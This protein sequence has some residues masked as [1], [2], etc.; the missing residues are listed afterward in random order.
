MFGRRCTGVLFAVLVALAPRVASGAGWAWPV[1]GSVVLPYAAAWTDAAGRTCTHGGVDIA[2]NGGAPVTASV[3]GRV[4]FAGR[5]PAASGG[6]V[7][8]VSVVTADGLRVTYMPLAA[9]DVSTGCDVEAGSR[10][11]TLADTGDRSLREPHLHLS[12]HRGET[13]ID[14]AAFLEGPATIAAPAAAGQLPPGGQSSSPAP[15]QVALSAPAPCLPDPAAMRA[16]PAQAVPAGPGF[17]VPL[18]L[19][20]RIDA[21]IRPLPVT[22]RLDPR[23]AVAQARAAALAGRG[24]AVRLLL[25]ALAL[26]ALVRLVG[27]AARSLAPCGSAAPVLADARRDRP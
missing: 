7:L 14:P 12:V 6:S 21:R 24:L 1:G 26:V 11:G 13:A 22:L 23:A 27:T 19:G 16:A 3:G 20:P 4:S 9:A 8:A 15:R 17:A 5:V 25:G 10:L 2:A 18:E